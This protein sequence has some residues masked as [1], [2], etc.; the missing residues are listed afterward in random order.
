MQWSGGI[1][2]RILT[3]GTRCC[4]WSTSGPDRFIPEKGALVPI[5]LE[6]G[7]LIR[8]VAKRKIMSCRE[9]KPSRPLHRLVT[10]LADILVHKVTE[11]VDILVHIVTALSDI[12]VQI[13]GF[14]LRAQNERVSV[15]LFRYPNHL[16]DLGLRFKLQVIM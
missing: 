8:L 14:V 5:R 13:F 4:E 6:G 2:L 10:A 3:L 11:L 1:T 7:W 9:L 16:R 12:L 15:L